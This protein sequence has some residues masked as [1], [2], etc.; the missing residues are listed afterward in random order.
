MKKIILL[1]CFP[2]MVNAQ[3]NDTSGINWIKTEHEFGQIKFDIPVTHKFKFVNKSK[4][5]VEITS[6]E[7]SCGC[8]QPKWTTSPI[9]PNDTAFVEATFNARTEGVFNKQVSVYTNRSPFP[10]R[11]ILKGEVI[12]N[13]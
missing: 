3:I 10:N 4:S 12:K 6:V 9:A 5:V 1:V 8:T 11:L 7:A 13:P 2:F